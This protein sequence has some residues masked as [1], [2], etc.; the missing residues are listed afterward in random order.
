MFNWI[1]SPSLVYGGLPSLH[2]SN[3]SQA[4]VPPAFLVTSYPPDIALYNQNSNLAVLLRSFI[5]LLN[6]T[7]SA[8]NYVINMAHKGH[9]HMPTLINRCQ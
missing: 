6:F 4:T 2:A 5:Y 1:F 7:A 8:H 3:S 9:L